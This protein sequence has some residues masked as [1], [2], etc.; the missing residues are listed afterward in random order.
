LQRR[1]L[2]IS[3]IIDIF[4]AAQMFGTTEGLVQIVVNSLSPG[5]ITTLSLDIPQD[6]R[7][8]WML[9]GYDFSHSCAV[10]VRVRW[11]NARNRRNT[12][13]FL[14]DTAWNGSLVGIQG[15]RD[16]LEG[17]TSTIEIANVTA[18]TGDPYFD[19][20]VPLARARAGA[21]VTVNGTLTG[22][23]TR[24]ERW[25]ARGAYAIGDEIQDRIKERVKFWG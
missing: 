3:P 9:S 12:L 1:E 4:Q 22:L 24:L 14:V 16:M 13:L 25:L 20:F 23:V 7:W 6:E 8:L 2:E 11:T 18:S 19:Q 10:A 17:T 15:W 5:T 21:N